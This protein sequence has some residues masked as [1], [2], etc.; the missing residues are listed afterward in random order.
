MIQKHFVHFKKRKKRLLKFLINK[1][2]FSGKV[3][4]CDENFCGTTKKPS[5]LLF[6]LNITMIQ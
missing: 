6:L 4:G 1:S 3:N 2:K 5:I